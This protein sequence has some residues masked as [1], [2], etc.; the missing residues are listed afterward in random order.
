MV[1]SMGRRVAAGKVWAARFGVL[2]NAN[3]RRYFAGYV[4]S[5]LGSAMAGVAV[6]FA[7]LDSG[8]TATDLGLVFAAGVVVQIALMIGGG[9]LAD[10]LG[11]R[12]VMLGADVFRTV[13]QGLLAVLLF[14]GQPPIWAFVVLTAARSAGD[15]LFQP[16]FNGL[17]VDITPQE[18]RG[19]ANALFGLS[20]SAAQVAGPALAGILVAV[21]DPAL[22]IAIDALSFAISAVALAGLALPA[23]PAGQRPS[24]LA[25]L[26]A[27]WGTF[28][29]QTWLWTITIQF[30]LFNLLS[31]APFLL[32][33][34]VLAKADLSGARSW[35][36]IMAAFAF[37]SV[38]AGLA[39]LGKRPPR[40]LLV[41]TIGTLAYP[42]P[43]ILL[44]VHASTAEIAAGA[45]IAGVGSTTC[46]I[47]FNATLQRVIPADMQARVTAFNLVCAFSAV[48]IGFAIAGPVAAAIGAHT[49]LAFGAA[50]SLA[51]TLVVFLVPSIRTT[52]WSPDEDHRQ[53]AAASTTA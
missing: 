47:F 48:P 32:L 45:L 38:I 16:A 33:G 20:S 51:S 41:A 24:F 21:G 11:R 10:R 14:A 25:D 37:G 4:S 52:R 36:A 46:N 39:A 28:R 15:A 9:V 12:R 6:A 50:W 5:S 26:A 3:V 42:L 49:V 1:P 53:S 43:L 31:W 23:M 40:P 17:I 34:P 44:A 18:E 27:G 30:T 29:S 22:V 13:C 19:D 2:R 7:V 8:G 35:G